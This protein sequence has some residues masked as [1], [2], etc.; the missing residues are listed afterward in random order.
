LKGN[1]SVRVEEYIRK[2]PIQIETK[3]R[4]LIEKELKWL[5][6]S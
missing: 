5:S 4:I 3:H 1:K 2:T 6:I